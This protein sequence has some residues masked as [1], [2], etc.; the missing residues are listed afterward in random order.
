MRAVIAPDLPPEFRTDNMTEDALFKAHELDSFDVAVTTCALAIEETG[1]IIL[2]CGKGQGRRALSLVP[3]RHICIVYEN[4]IR[5]TVHE[6]VIALHEPVKNGQPLTFISGPS[7]TS[8]IELVRVEGVH[9][10][11]HLTVLLITE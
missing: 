9:G 11:R 5:K 4:Q 6:A 10:P 3:D 1:T 7:A 2:D 8:D